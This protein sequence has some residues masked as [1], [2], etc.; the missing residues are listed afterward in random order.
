MSGVNKRSSAPAPAH[1]SVSHFTMQW[2][3]KEW[4]IAE[5]E[6]IKKSLGEERARE[7][8]RRWRWMEKG[9]VE[10]SV[11]LKEMGIQ[12]YQ[13]FCRNRRGAEN[14]ECKFC[15]ENNKTLNK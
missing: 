12:E 2:E 10:I 15:G 1:S 8:R 13:L 5:C 3:T 9:K 4:S 6:A 11:W 14:L 7:E